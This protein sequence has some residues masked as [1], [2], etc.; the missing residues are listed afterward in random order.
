MADATILSFG[1]L[2]SAGST[3][4][5]ASSA[6]ALDIEDTA[7]QDYITVDTTN[8]KLIFATNGVD[9]LTVNK[10]G[11]LEL[12]F[13]SS[14]DG[15]TDYTGTGNVAIGDATTL[16]SVGNN[17]VANNIAIGSD[18]LKSLSGTGSA[19]SV[20]NVAIGQDAMESATTAY[21][22]VC[23]GKDAGQ[24]MTTSGNN[25]F[26]GRKAGFSTD[27]GSQNVCIG[28]DAGYSIG[29]STHNNTIV[30][31]TESG[32]LLTSA[33]CVLLGANIA[34]AMTAGANTIAI[35]YQ[36]AANV[37]GGSANSN[38]SLGNNNIYIGALTRTSR[39]GALTSPAV[40]AVTNSMTLGYNATE[41]GSNSVVLGPTTN[42]STFFYGS[43]RAKNV[44]TTQLS[45]SIDPT[46]STTVTG[47]NTLFLDELAIGDRITV[48]SETRTVTAIA[49]NTSLTVD[50]A[51]T[52][53][54][55]D[56][57][58][59]K[60]PAHLVLSDSSGNADFIVDD[61]GKVGIGKVPA[62]ALDVLVDA[63]G[64][65]AAY[66]KNDSASGDCLYLTTDA[67]GGDFILHCASP[68][69]ADAFRVAANGGLSVG[70][71]PTSNS[72]LAAGDIYADGSGD[73]ATLKIKK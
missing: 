70:S 38:T 36:A 20:D 25:I 45:G 14:A 43:V 21:G 69:S 73:G 17:V 40:A 7:G 15:A 5:S 44:G 31:G 34:P 59:D 9:R 30:G 2:I 8:E 27:T 68:V 49:S 12:G 42:L 28:E 65:F 22:N 39:A 71:L 54:A 50:A 56:T 1:Q 46:A 57:S 24:A 64:T 55:N 67:T 61:A 48:S 60:L 58:P 53:T 62:Y 66:I 4:I 13:L 72:G 52:N 3:A 35:G 32:K 23:I 33:Q 18:A 26:L 6:T 16:S 63:A 11:R 37:A 10:S 47:V 19:G 41:R 29:S 51:T